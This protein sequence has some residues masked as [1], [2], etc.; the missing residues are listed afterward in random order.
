MVRPWS[1]TWLESYVVV[2]ILEAIG[3]RK[4]R[5]KYDSNSRIITPKV[6]VLKLLMTNIK[7]K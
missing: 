1:V 3:K 4:K 6:T 5:M 2:V 7:L